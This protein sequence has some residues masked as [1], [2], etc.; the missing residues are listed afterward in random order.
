MRI[1]QNA[2]KTVL[3]LMAG[4]EAKGLSPVPVSFLLEETVP[5][6]RLLYNTLTKELLFLEDGED[7]EDYLRRHFFLKDPETDERSAAR[8]IRDTLMFAAQTRFSGYTR[9]TILP[10]TDCNARCFYCY[11]AGCEK[12]EMD[13]AVTEDAIS[14][15]LNTCGEGELTLRFF[16]GE[17]LMGEAALDRICSALAEN[18]KIFKSRIVTN[19]YL[20][21][22]ELARKAHSL[23]RLDRAQITLDGTESVYNARKSF[24]QDSDGAF[25]RVMDNIGLLLENDIAVQIRLNMDES[26]YQ[27]LR[28]LA[29]LLA[30]RYG[31]REKF[32]VYPFLLFQDILSPSEERT[33]KLFSMYRAF[34]GELERLG[35]LSRDKLPDKLKLN[36]CMAD[37][38]ASVVI[39]PDGRIGACEHFNET[40]FFGT[41]KEGESKS[42][43]TAYWQESFPE[44][45]FCADCP[46]Y[47]DCFRMLHCPDRA[48][49]C[50]PGQREA[51]IE[52][53]RRSMRAACQY[54][55][56]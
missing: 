18:G 21:T 45:A 55:V 15:I 26:N 11:E 33:E 34:C 20:F 36:H 37:D 56:N 5:G 8:E 13:P 47:P 51:E 4:K 27:D 52:R 32:S 9:Y 24:V 10:T 14:F 49:R 50:I 7:Q 19:G 42:V 46:L 22:P 43:S 38:P 2:R 53:L 54:Y 3:M 44:E 35:L 16:G 23:W 40:P 41:L 28:E 12:I 31:K 29:D 6:G 25:R 1:L 17:P 30:A 48:D 39:L